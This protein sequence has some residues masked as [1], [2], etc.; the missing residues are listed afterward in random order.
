MLESLSNSS[1]QILAWLVY[2]LAGTG[3]SAVWWRMTRGIVNGGWRDILRGLLVVLI[4]TPWYSGE[5]AEYFAPA[6]LILMMD[7]LLDGARSGLQGGIALLFSSFLMLL[8]LSV[9]LYFRR[10]PI[11]L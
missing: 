7:L 4:F 8:I 6:I 5:Q 2:L 1:D 9:R 10:K 11:Q 3:C